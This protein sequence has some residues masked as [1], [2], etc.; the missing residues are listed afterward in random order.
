M[1]RQ[2]SAKPDTCTE[3]RDV[4]PT[5]ISVKVSASYPGRSGDLL[6]KLPASRGAGR[7]CQKSAEAIVGGDTEGP[8]GEC[9]EQAAGTRV[10]ADEGRNAS[11]R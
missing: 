11:T 9:R 1:S 6:E 4:Y 8:N 10:K 2:I 7:G 5:G 3:R